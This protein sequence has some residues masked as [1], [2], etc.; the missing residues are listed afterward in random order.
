[1]TNK[2]KIQILK[3]ELSDQ[4]F[5]DLLES[6]SLLKEKLDKCFSASDAMK[7][8]DQIYSLLTPITKSK[9]NYARGTA[10]M[11]LKAVDKRMQEAMFGDGI[12]L[13]D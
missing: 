2:E 8:R 1:M 12:W 11:I 13:I 4:Q 5:K 6:V 9:G 3:T 7:I 10:K